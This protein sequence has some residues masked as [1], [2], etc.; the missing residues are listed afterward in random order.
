MKRHLLDQLLAARANRQAVAL[1][2]H[3]DTGEQRIVPRSAA[4]SDPLA[5]KL[6][7]AFRFDQSGSHDGQFINI[8]NPPLRL[9]I[10]GAVHIAQSVI[11][12]AQQLGYDVTVIDPR[13]AF[14]T[15]ARFPGIS[16]HAEWPDEVIPQIGLDPRTALVALTHDPKIDDPALN[17]ALKSDVF[18]IGALGSKKTQASRA[19]RLKEA[20]FSDAQI[21]RIHGPIGLNI[22]AKGAPEIAVSIMGEVTRCLRLGA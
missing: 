12:I 3:L 21:A 2:T 4:A 6:D 11:P 15:G 16:L 20:G 22:S 9:V 5:A 8:H 13:G 7:E 14:A 18:Y 19:Q 1:I 10:I 17:A